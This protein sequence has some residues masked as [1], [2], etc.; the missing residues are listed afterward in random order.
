MPTLYWVGKGKVVNHHH[1]VPFRV[2]NK[3]SIIYADRCLSSAAFMTRHG[4]LFKK[5]PQDI[6]RF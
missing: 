2:L 6:T 4:I 1:G 5:I 3:V